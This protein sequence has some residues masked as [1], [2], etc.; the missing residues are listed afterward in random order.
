MFGSRRVVPMCARS[1]PRLRWLAICC[2]NITSW[3]YARLLCIAVGLNVD[4]QAAVFAV[5]ERGAHRG[6]R[7]VAHGSRSLPAD[8]LMMFV[9]VPQPAG[10]AADESLPGNE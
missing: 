6:R 1:A 7:A 8:V 10:P 9:E 2:T 3:W 4:R 5:G